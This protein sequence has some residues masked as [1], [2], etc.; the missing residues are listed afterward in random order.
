MNYSVEQLAKGIINCIINAE[1]LLVCAEKMEKNDAGISFVLT[2]HAAEELGKIVLICGYYN[3]HP[4]RPEV[5]IKKFLTHETKQRYTKIIDTIPNHEIDYSLSI[6]EVQKEKIRLNVLYT[7]LTKKGIEL[8]VKLNLNTVVKYR[9]TVTNRLT[10]LKKWHPNKEEVEKFIRRM[11]TLDINKLMPAL[12][13][14]IK[15]GKYKYKH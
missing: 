12:E 1:R 6:L 3:Y 4:K 13:E 10:Q 9:K 15:T 8:P 11:S 7:R 2:C 5:W 14:Y